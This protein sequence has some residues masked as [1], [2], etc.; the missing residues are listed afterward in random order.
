MDCVGPDR[1]RP[2]RSPASRTH[3]ACT[4]ILAPTPH[5][6]PLLATFFSSLLEHALGRP[7]RLV[8]LG[9]PSLPDL[10]TPQL[11]GACSIA[12]AASSLPRAIRASLAQ[13][14]SRFRSHSEQTSGPLSKQRPVSPRFRCHSSCRWP[15]RATPGILYLH[16]SDRRLQSVYLC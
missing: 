3:A 13:F 9:R 2:R 16:T 7:T 11:Q 14:G 8:F 4:L 15:W 12:P 5:P 6:R 10:P 1:S